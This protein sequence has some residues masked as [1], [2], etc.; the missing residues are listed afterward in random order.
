MEKKRVVVTGLGA[1]TPLGNTVDSYWN[2]LIAGKSGADYITK[3]DASLFKTQFACEVKDFDPL[4][5]M[6]RKEVR[7]LEKIKFTKSKNSRIRKKSQI[8][9]IHEFEKFTKSKNRK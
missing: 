1:L 5:I 2:N 9:K 4:E 3:F 8:Q 6:D 7:K